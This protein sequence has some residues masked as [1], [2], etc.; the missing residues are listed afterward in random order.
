MLF[1]FLLVDLIMFL[2]MDISAISLGRVRLMYRVCFSDL[3]D[4]RGGVQILT[5]AIWHNLSVRVTA[6]AAT[7]S[8][9][10]EQVK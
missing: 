10:G 3:S 9:A 7:T 2:W 6:A 5:A 1:S 8:C 4:S